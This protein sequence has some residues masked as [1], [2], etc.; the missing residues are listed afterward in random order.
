MPA[1]NFLIGANIS[2]FS[3][4]SAHKRAVQSHGLILEPEV[5]KV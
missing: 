3:L 4:S 2:N 5:V 1:E